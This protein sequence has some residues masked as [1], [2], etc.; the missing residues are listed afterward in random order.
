[1]LL[2]CS[3]VIWSSYHKS[4]LASSDYE[5]TV[6]L[7]D[8]FACQKTRV[9]QVCAESKTQKVPLAF[10]DLFCWFCRM[11]WVAFL[12]FA[13]CLQDYRKN[14][15][16]IFGES[17]WVGTLSTFKG[18]DVNTYTTQCISSLSYP[19]ACSVSW[20]IRKWRSAAL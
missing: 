7:W 5:G 16:M 15:Q 19:W 20:W 3:S 4:M 10:C 6:T 18:W 14:Y 1:M 2:L 17:L 11:K 12:V 9:F 8:A 13:V